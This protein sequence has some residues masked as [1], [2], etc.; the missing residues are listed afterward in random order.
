MNHSQGVTAAEESFEDVGELEVVEWIILL[1]AYDTYVRTLKEKTGI[2]DPSDP[3][4]AKGHTLLRTL[5][6]TRGDEF[7]GFLLEHMPTDNMKKMLARAF[8]LGTSRSTLPKQALQIRTILSRGGASTLRKIFKSNRAINEIRTAMDSSCLEDGPQALDKFAVIT[9][10]NMRIRTWIATAAQVAGS[11]SFQDA[12]SA[13]ATA[14][15]DDAHALALTHARGAAAPPL[16]EESHQAATDRT[17]QT[18][19]VETV[20][21]EAAKKAL[22]VSGKPDVPPTRSEVIGIATAATVAAKAQTVPETLAGLDAE[23]VDAALTDGRVLVMAGAGSGKTTTLTARVAYLVKDKKANP[24]RIMAI[25]FNRKAAREIKERI[26]A[27]VGDDVLS[28]MHVGTMHGMFRKFVVEHGTPEEKAALTTWLMTT[29]SKKGG[30]EQR[31]GRAPSPS[32]FSGYMSRIWKECFNRDP[33]KRGKNIIQ[34]WVMNDV[35]P[36]QAKANAHTEEQR[37]LAEWYTWTLGFKGVERNWQP[38]CVRSNFKAGKQWGEFL[39]KWRDNGKARLGDFSDMI[40]LFRD[41][42]VR[43]PEVRKKIQGMFDHILVD[44]AQDLNLVQHQIIDLMAEHIG[45][46]SDGRSEWLVGDEVQSINRFVGARPELLTQFHGKSGWKTKSIKTNYRCLPEIVEHANQLMT[47]HER[48][49]PMEARPDATK[50]RGEASIVVQSPPTHAAGALTVVSQIKQD[51][52]S[53]IPL[54]DHAILTRTNMEQNDFET[55]CIIQG[56]PYARKGGTSFLKSPETITV[57]SYVNLAVGQ[58]FSRMQKSLIEVLNKPNRFYLRAGESERIITEVVE[59]RARIR[60]VSVDTINPIDLFDREGIQLFINV[61][62][63]SRRWEGWKVKATVEELENLGRSLRGM[64]Q[65][66]ADGKTYDR[67]SGKEKAYS[68]QDL[69]G[70]ILAI[71]GVPEQRGSQPPTLRDVLMPRQS[72]HEEESDA[73]ADPDDDPS[74]KPV[75][76]VEFLFQIAQPDPEHPDTDPSDPKKFKARIDKLAVGARDLRVDLDRWDFEQQKLPPNERKSPPCVTLST[77]HSVKGAQWKNTTVVM[78]KG[79]FPFEPKPDPNEETLPPEVQAEIQKE[80]DAEFRT[81]RQLAYVAMTRAAK[82][83]TIVCPAK[84]VYG[85]DAGPSVFVSE[86][87][88]MQ[89]QNV[90]GKNDPTPDMGTNSTV[91]SHMIASYFSSGAPEDP[92]EESDGVTSYDRRMP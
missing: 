74:K 73:P 25:S 38:P 35:T 63:P 87:G 16:S 37:Q 5:N 31:P 18:T 72:S 39:A 85:R 15:Q 10:K 14:T 2:Q 27:R 64:R 23:Q 83:L 6:S 8:R 29:P 78:A 21:T 82:N 55:A 90:S 88:L 50:N 86:A 49:V 92:R 65:T 19:L 42:L 77:I 32:A 68:T 75:G 22:T 71:Q 12:V 43:N 34:A 60:N 28:H 67:F 44:E 33:P 4:L 36:E 69:F 57:M 20:A 70:D 7:H 53:G 11:G 17:S 52:D 47:H 40:L 91:V 45:D 54:E 84:S 46:G 3:T 26:G 80:R 13:A 61:M 24:G 89:G 48:G 56:I 76:N 41:L 9:I 51:V 62:D 66:V 1:L 30:E 79:V 59:T 58:D 81:E